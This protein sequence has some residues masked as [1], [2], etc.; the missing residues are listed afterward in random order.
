MLLKRQEELE[1]R[2]LA[3]HTCRLHQNGFRRFA[4]EKARWIAA[5]L[6]LACH[7]WSN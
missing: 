5:G 2:A 6:L 1:C 4:N 7:F 3:S